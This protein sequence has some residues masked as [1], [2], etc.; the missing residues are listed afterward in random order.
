EKLV[1]LE[2][3]L[4]YAY[5]PGLPGIRKRPGDFGLPERAHLYGCPQSLFKFHPDFDELLGAILRRD[6]EGILVLHRAERSW[7][8]PWVEALKR[9]FSTTLGDVQE[10]IRFLP[11]LTQ[12][13]YL[14][15]TTLCD[16]LLDTVP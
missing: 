9:R 2:T 3:P 15:L 14:I 6:P 7:F 4:H 10:R 12:P 16:V 8:E 5:R 11:W 13:E 1:R